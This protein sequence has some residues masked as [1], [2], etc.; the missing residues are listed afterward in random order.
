MIMENISF[1]DG[2]TLENFLKN[3]GNPPLPVFNL[4]LSLHK[5]QA[6][7]RI[8]ICQHQAQSLE[9]NLILKIFPF[10]F[11]AQFMLTSANPPQDDPLAL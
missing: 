10:P 9:F 6:Q 3:V 8:T 5:F 1:I 11:I 4:K 7:R 2:L